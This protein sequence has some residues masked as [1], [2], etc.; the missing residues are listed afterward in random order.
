MLSSQAKQIPKEMNPE[1]M[2]GFPK[3]QLDKYGKNESTDELKKIVE[4]YI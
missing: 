2:K 3:C 1:L 4:S